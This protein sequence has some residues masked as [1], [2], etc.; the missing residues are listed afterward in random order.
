MY[1]TA[2]LQCAQERA[3]SNRVTSFFAERPSVRWTEG[4]WELPTKSNEHKKMISVCHRDQPEQLA[5]AVFTICSLKLPLL[6]CAC[7]SGS[8]DSGICLDPTLICSGSGCAE[9]CPGQRNGSPDIPC[10]PSL[11][12]GSSGAES[13]PLVGTRATPLC[14]LQY[15]VG[16]R[17]PVQDVTLRQVPTSRRACTHAPTELLRRLRAPLLPAT[18]LGMAFAV[19]EWCSTH[20]SNHLN[21]YSGISAD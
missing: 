16:F 10:L 21:P 1:D 3:C 12:A 19:Q 14:Y 17:A 2:E 9:K 4:S 8:V 7:G 5:P 6:L 18:L 13:W 15:M 11:S 20:P